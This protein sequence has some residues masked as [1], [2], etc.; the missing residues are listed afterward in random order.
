MAENR[1]APSTPATICLRW[2]GASSKAEFVIQLKLYV[3]TIGVSTYQWP[4]MRLPLAAKDAQDLATALKRQ[5][6][7]LYRA[8]EVKLLTDAQAHKEGT[9]D[10]LEWLERQTT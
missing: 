8:V 5:H 10:G 9:L 1:H 4:D 2:Q 3:L 6:W 7:R